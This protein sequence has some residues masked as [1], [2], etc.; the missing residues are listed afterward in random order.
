[1]GKTV[2]ISEKIIPMLQKNKDFAS[3]DKYELNVPNGLEYGNVVYEKKKTRP[4]KVDNIRLKSFRVKEK[5]YPFFWKDNS[6]KSKI[7]LRLLDIADDFWK[8]LNLDNIKPKGIILTGSICGYDWS[9]YSDIDLHIVVDFKKIHKDKDFVQEFFNNAKNMWNTQHENLLILKHK[10][11]VYVEDVDANTKSN[12]IYD[13]EDNTWISEPTKKE[14]TGINLDKYIIKDKSVDIINNINHL[15]NL[16][17]KTEDLHILGV[18]NDEVTELL[19][20]LQ[21]KR[22][23]GLEK[24]GDI[25]IDNIVYKVLRRTGHLEILRN[26]SN[27]LY[28]KLNSINESLNE[29]VVADGSAEHNPFEKRWKM[30][31][32]TLKSFIMNNGILMTSRE[33]GK[34]Y[35]VYNINQLSNLIGYNYAL[36]LEFDPTT[37]EEGTTVY[38][39]ALDKFTRRIF[40]AQFDTRGKDNMGG[41]NDDVIQ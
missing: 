19:S 36:C 39:R 25:S 28:D 31:R 3:L 35:K 13:L 5:L 9:K 11:E 8:S 10:V 27:Y 14:F 24:D 41:T 15:Y 38:I 34:L 12:G 26:L 16:A 6:L 22:K 4:I 20:S 40:S 21:E 18:I 29:E 33:N 23:E 32:D 30:E 17:Y 2:F 37:M 1:M 7:R